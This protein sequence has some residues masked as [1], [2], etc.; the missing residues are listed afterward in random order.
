VAEP[1]GW[2]TEF[3]HV[4]LKSL[5]ELVGDEP[6]SFIKIDVEGMELEVLKSA[7]GILAKSQP[8]IFFEAWSLDEFKTQVDHL[9]TFVAAQGYEVIRI[10]SD[11]LAYPP[12]R[13]HADQ[14]HALL[15]Q[16]GVAPG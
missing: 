9:L 16:A 5:D 8:V 7:P 14:V 12:A 3:D 10:G 15:Q 13:F 4:A 1:Q 2:A 11:C 6:V